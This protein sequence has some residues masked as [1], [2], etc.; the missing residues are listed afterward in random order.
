MATKIIVGKS[1]IHGKGI[2]ANQNIKRKET[3]FIIRGKMIRW[4]VKDQKTSLYGPAWI[5]MNKNLWIDPSEPANLLNHSC[6]PNSGIKGKLKVVALKNIKKGEEIT[7]DYSI[8]EMDELWH[9]K[10]KCGNKNCRKIIRS[11]QTL[12]LKIYKKYTPFIPTYFMKV[13]N[14]CHNGK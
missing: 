12:P 5:G 13:Y 10:C 9:M 11:I 3:I 6:D 1:G 2:F 7:I 8:T 14:R 4:I